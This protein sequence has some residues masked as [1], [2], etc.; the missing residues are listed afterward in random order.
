M[1]SLA[2]IHLRALWRLADLYGEESFLRAATRA[3]DYRRFNAEAI[4][5]ILE[6]ENP[7]PENP[8]EIVPLNVSARA[9]ALLSEVDPGSLDSYGHLD[10][11][12]VST[13]R[14]ESSDDATVE[15]ISSPDPKQHDKE[16]LHD[17]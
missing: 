14:E 1:K 13:P 6:R 7:L 16:E 8:P 9:L 15:Q 11:E 4:R 10:T 3:Q 5:R 17:S 12:G 2:H